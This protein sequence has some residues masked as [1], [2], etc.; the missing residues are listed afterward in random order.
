ARARAEYILPLGAAGRAPVSGHRF[1]LLEDG[2]VPDVDFSGNGL[3]A[4]V[5]GGA[6]I[7]TGIETGEVHLVVDVLDGPPPDVADGWEEIVE[8]SW[9]AFA[10]GAS[11]AGAREPHLSR[12]T[13][14][15][16]GDYRLRVHARGRDVPDGTESYRLMVWEAPAAA[17]VVHARADR[18]GHR[19]RG[20]PEP[21][22]PPEAA[23]RWLAGTAL[24]EAA[25]VT[26]V[27]GAD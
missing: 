3:V 17:E 23:Y 25:T 8:V 5:A 9:R 26:V 12:L 2:P 19:L 13:P 18:L 22:E 15:W 14:P 20:E 11:V 21:P 7:R 4:V 16:P 10:G 6:V 24:A 27:T 1:A